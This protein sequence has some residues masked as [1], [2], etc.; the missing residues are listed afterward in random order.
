MIP[1]LV[2]PVPPLDTAKVPERSPKLK[3]LLNSLKSKLERDVTP[4]PPFASGKVPVTFEVKLTDIDS[5]DHV[6]ALPATPSEA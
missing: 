1:P 2:V 4:V 6:L 3:S 5:N